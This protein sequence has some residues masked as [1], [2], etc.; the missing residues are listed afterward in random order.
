MR[1]FAGPVRPPAPYAIRIP[2][3]PHTMKRFLAILLSALFLTPFP[4]RAG[5]NA[6][7]QTNLVSDQ[8]GKANHTDSQLVNPWGIAFL[9]GAP[10]WVAD[11]NSG[12]STIYDAN[13]VKASLVVTI[14]AFGGSGTGTPTGIVANNTVNFGGY[15]F[16]F[17]TED[18]SIVGWKSGT[19]GIFLANQP[20]AVYKGLA[21]ITNASGSFLLATNFL[22]GTVD[23]YDTNVRPTSL[24]GNFTDPTAPA[25]YAP[26]GIHVVGGMV[27]VTYA[28]QDTS[29]RDPVLGKGLGFVDVF[30]LN[31]SLVKRFATGGMLN[32]PWGTVLA[33]A[34]GFG[35]FSGA[36]LVGNFGTGQIVA[37]DATT[38]KSL[39]MMKDAQGKAIKNS[40]LWEM[41]YGAGGTGSP[42]TLYIAAGIKN[43]THGL[44]AAIS[45]VPV[46][47]L[48]ASLKFSSPV[49]KTSASKVATLSNNSAA[50]ITIN[51]VA[52]NDSHFIITSN[53]C[54]ATLAA[55]ASCKIKVAFLPTQKGTVTG[56]LSVT[57]TGAGSPQTAA[58]TG[59]GT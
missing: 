49:S 43:E 11:N 31:G 29:K 1:G 9:P 23:V 57:D 17:C 33:P 10:F 32:A 12:V 15:A 51:S 36:L 25:G 48:P 53:T 58:L 42:T 45:V 39:G 5:S 14:P 44:F 13:G 46:T 47:L 55:G 41:V 2:G 30:D 59:T 4:A 8:S 6:F 56:T 26:F 24:P 27:Y 38:G 16:L 19:T 40:G 54:G 21:L 18:G 50:A 7:Q 20:S 35:A 22:A 28:K 34:S 37:Y 3:E 52:V